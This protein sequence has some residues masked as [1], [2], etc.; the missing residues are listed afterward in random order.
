MAYRFG[1]FN[2]YKFSFRSDNEIKK[3]IDLIAQIIYAT[4]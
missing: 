2:M 3:D 1:S 4:I